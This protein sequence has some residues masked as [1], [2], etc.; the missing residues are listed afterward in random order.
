M[1]RQKEEEIFAY[2]ATRTSLEQI[3]TT[4]SHERISQNDENAVNRHNVWLWSIFVLSAF[5]KFSVLFAG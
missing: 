1:V 2:T 4:F 5:Y 3:K